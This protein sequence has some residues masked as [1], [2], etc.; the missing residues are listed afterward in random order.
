M[1]FRSIWGSDSNFSFS[2]L[3]PQRAL[4]DAGYA[5]PGVDLREDFR[6]AGIIVPFDGSVHLPEFYR[7]TRVV[8]R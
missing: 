5:G 2:I 8:Q 4:S 7:E 6:A 1:L 3:N